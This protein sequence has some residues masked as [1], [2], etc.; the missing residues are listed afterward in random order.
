[1]E[2]DGGSRS[3]GLCRCVDP[4]SRVPAL[5]WPKLSL[6]GEEGKV[7]MQRCWTPGDG[8]EAGTKRGIVCCSDKKKG[9]DN[10]P[11]TPKHRSLDLSYIPYKYI[12][13][14]NFLFI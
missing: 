8:Q 9:G 3:A 14:M 5:P 11:L 7:S 1:M 12:H 2:S 6:G 13:K 10:S 4:L